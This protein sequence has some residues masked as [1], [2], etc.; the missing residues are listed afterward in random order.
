M[1]STLELQ[2]KSKPELLELLNEKS[3]KLQGLRFDISFNRLKDVSVIKKT[4]RDIARINT[5]L[6]QK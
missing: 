3:K 2:T 5:L 6:N 1:K 4:K